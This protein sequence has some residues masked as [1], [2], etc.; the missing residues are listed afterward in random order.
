MNIAKAAKLDQATEAVDHLLH[1][2]LDA[3]VIL[4]ADG[5]MVRGNAKA[6]KLFGCSRVE[7]LGSPANWP[8]SQEQ[9]RD[10]QFRGIRERT[11][12]LDRGASARYIRVYPSPVKQPSESRQLGERSSEPWKN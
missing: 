8:C 4:G 12:A 9:P 1:V 7:L 5:R 11:K 10:R 3:M 6:E 2:V